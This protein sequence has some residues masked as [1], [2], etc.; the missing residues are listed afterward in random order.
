MRKA[1]ILGRVMSLAFVLG[2]TGGCYYALLKTPDS[3]PPKTSI[4]DTFLGDLKF[5]LPDMFV[6]NKSD[7]ELSL[8]NFAPDATLVFEDRIESMDIESTDCQGKATSRHGATRDF[9]KLVEIAPD[10]DYAGS[11]NFI[12]VD[13]QRTCS[14]HGLDVTKEQKHE[15]EEQKTEKQ[16]TEKPEDD[17][18]SSQPSTPV[19]PEMIFLNSDGKV[20]FRIDDGD[21][22]F[23]SFLLNV[24]DGAN[25][26]TIHYYGKCLKYREGIDEGE[27]LNFAMN[28]LEAE[29]LGHK[30]ILIQLNVD[31]PE[32]PGVLK[33]DSCYKPASSQIIE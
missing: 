22:K 5:Q 3:S 15:G 8:A 4:P 19:T 24:K 14:T 31:R 18:Q 27:R 2:N 6:C 16:E 30:K 17:H 33:R 11:V 13:N 1:K 21:F 32:V 10:A 23:Y 26:V 12:K 20:K 29:D 25:P 28:C 9:K 7:A